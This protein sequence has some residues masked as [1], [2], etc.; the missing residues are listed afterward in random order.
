MVDVL[1]QKQA[2]TGIKLLGTA[3]AFSH[4]R[5]MSGAGTNPDADIFS[6]AALQVP[7]NHANATKT[8]GGVTTCWGGHVKATR[9]CSAPILKREAQQFGRFR[10]KWSSSTEFTKIGLPGFIASRA[11]A[12]RLGSDSDC[13]SHRRAQ[14]VGPGEQVKVSTSEA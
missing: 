6:L 2:D 14:T 7:G 5:F 4:R 3:N 13:S 10:R 8:L 1:G 9:P 12:A 11:E